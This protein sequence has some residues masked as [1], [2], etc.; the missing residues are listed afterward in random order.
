MVVTV[1]QIADNGMTGMPGTGIIS[2]GK[3][4]AVKNVHMK[5]ASLKIPGRRFDSK[6]GVSGCVT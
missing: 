1:G 3:H 5:F 2:S 6:A 4:L